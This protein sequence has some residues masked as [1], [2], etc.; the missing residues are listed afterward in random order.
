MYIY[1]LIM[2][3]NKGPLLLKH[4]DLNC[5][6]GPLLKHSKN[7]FICIQLLCIHNN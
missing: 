4:Y 5:E 6:K 2:N 1:D 7:S 3:C